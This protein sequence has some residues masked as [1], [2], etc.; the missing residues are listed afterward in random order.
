MKLLI[1]FCCAALPAVTIAA[2]SAPAPTA[3][4]FN[5]LRLPTVSRADAFEA[6]LQATS[7]RFRV[8][9]LDREAGVIVSVPNEGT[10]VVHQ[11]RVGDLLGVPRRVRSTATIQVTGSDSAA[12][13]WCKIVVEVYETQEQRLYAQAHALDDL[14]TATPADRAGATTPEQNEVWRVVRRDKRAER[15]LRQAISEIVHRTPPAPDGES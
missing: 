8:A 12:E 13:V 2:C 10:E 9:R 15:N 7:E 4:T 1:R 11:G 6:A 14:P 3:R 5:Y